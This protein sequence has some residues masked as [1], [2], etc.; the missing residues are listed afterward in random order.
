MTSAINYSRC[1][2]MRRTPVGAS[3]SEA[4]HRNTM[5]R[6]TPKR[7]RCA[8]DLFAK[9]GGV[10]HA[11]DDRLSTP[12][13]FPLG[14]RRLHDGHQ[15]RSGRVLQRLRRTQLRRRRCGQPAV[16][17]VRYAAAAVIVDADADDHH[18]PVGGDG[19]NVR[20]RLEVT[21]LCTPVPACAD[22]DRLK[23]N[24][25][26]SC[27]RREVPGLAFEAQPPYVAATA[28]L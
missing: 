21:H 19:N 25:R 16:G 28:T 24:R 6:E 18:Q 11:G 22:G 20:K 4:S 12:C 23:G 3:R 13:T 14:V 9:I 26:S 1:A 17:Q 8:R 2:S 10:R 15:G 7:S 27:M 5:R